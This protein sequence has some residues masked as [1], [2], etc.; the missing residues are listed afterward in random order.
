MLQQMLFITDGGGPEIQLN[1]PLSSPSPNDTKWF[2]KVI[3]TV[4][5]LLDRTRVGQPITCHT[6]ARN[7]Q[8]N[9]SAYLEYSLQ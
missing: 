9:T 3:I 5:P 4:L 8:M 7:V 6:A 1:R 2:S